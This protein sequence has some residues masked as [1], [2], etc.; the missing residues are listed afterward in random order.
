LPVRIFGSKPANP[1]S[2]FPSGRLCDMYVRSDLILL[3][4]FCHVSITPLSAYT[5]SG[6]HVAHSTAPLHRQS[7]RSLPLSRQKPMDV[8]RSAQDKGPLRPTDG[9]REPARGHEGVSPWDSTSLC[10]PSN[11]GSERN[12]IGSMIY[13]S[14]DR[15][16]SGM[17][18][19]KRQ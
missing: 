8:P 11:R 9:R 15:R 1:L 16:Q 7:R 13:S 19:H 17:M 5:I 4:S 6:A 3:C 14:T 12:W 10:S 2:G 18:V